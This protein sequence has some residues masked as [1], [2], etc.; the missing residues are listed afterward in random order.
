MENFERRVPNPGFLMLCSDD[1]FCCIRSKN[2]PKPLQ[3]FKKPETTTGDHQKSAQP[4]KVDG[5]PGKQFKCW[6]NGDLDSSIS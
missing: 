2:T 3:L 5:V 6:E 4:M 1:L